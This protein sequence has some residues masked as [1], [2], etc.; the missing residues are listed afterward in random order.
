MAASGAILKALGSLNP[1]EL[2]AI[3]T[4]ATGLLQRPAQETQAQTSSSVQALVPP[5]QSVKPNDLSDGHHPSVS[6]LAPTQAQTLICQEPKETQFTLDFKLESGALTAM[7]SMM[8]KN[9]QD[10]FKES[11]IAGVVDVNQLKRGLGYMQV[12]ILL[13]NMRDSLVFNGLEIEAW[14]EHYLM[15]THQTPDDYHLFA[16]LWCLIQCCCGSRC[17]NFKCQK[18]SSPP[19]AMAIRAVG[20]ILVKW[21]RAADDGTG[22]EDSSKKAMDLLTELFGFADNLKEMNTFLERLQCKSAKR[23]FHVEDRKFGEMVEALRCDVNSFRAVMFHQVRRLLLG[24]KKVADCGGITAEDL[25]LIHEK[26]R[27]SN[28]TLTDGETLRD[29]EWCLN[30]DYIKATQVKQRFRLEEYLREESDPDPRRVLRRKYAR[31]IEALQRAVAEKVWEE[32]M[33]NP[34]MD[35]KAAEKIEMTAWTTAL[36]EA[37]LR[38]EKF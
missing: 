1:D 5:Q 20:D 13:P 6:A 11:L 4:T 37:A 19:G 9:E 25:H 12:K 31:Q 29:F 26:V 24:L 10:S 22:F 32:S 8:P 17:G 2:N 30:A 27:L 33:N 7:V 38:A 21:R 18:A 15:N 16:K 34:S 3:I 35:W 36:S 23:S 14:I 28:P